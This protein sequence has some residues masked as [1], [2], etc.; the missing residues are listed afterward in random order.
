MQ[1]NTPISNSKY[2]RAAQAAEYFRI[3]KSTLWLWTKTLPGFPQPVKV[4]KRVTLF[5]LQ[6]IETY[7][8][9]QAGGKL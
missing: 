5:D 2:A 8:A 3:G 1:N 6:A 7:F 9:A 4:G